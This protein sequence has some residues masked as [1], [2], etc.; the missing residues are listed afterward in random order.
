MAWDPRTKSRGICWK[1][2]WP[3]RK[4]GEDYGF[5]SSINSLPTKKIGEKART[6]L[7]AWHLLERTE[8]ILIAPTYR[9]GEKS[10]G[11]GKGVSLICKK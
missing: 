11:N 2:E 8:S 3:G 7:T 9:N 5:R 10:M 1:S 6:G 4:C